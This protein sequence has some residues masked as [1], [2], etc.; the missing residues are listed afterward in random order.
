MFDLLA[1]IPRVL[2]SEFQ[3]RHQ[4]LLENLALRHQLP[5]LQRSVPQSQTQECRPV[6][7]GTAAALL[8]RVAAGV[9]NR[10]AAHDRGLA[11]GRI[12]VQ[13]LTLGR[14][15]DERVWSFFHQ[16]FVKV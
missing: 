15:G 2:F 9:G 13:H 12:P 1:T 3:S 14:R 8:V 11:S 5:V 6:S 16:Q 7:V 10:S 4:L